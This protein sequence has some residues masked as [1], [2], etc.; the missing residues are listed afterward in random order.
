MLLRMDNITLGYTF[1]K[2]GRESFLR[3]FAGMQNVFVIRDYSD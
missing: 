2:M 3:L 1:Q